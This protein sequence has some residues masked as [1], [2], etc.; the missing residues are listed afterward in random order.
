MD[1]RQLHKFYTCKMAT[2]MSIPPRLRWSNFVHDLVIVDIHQTDINTGVRVATLLIIVTVLGLITKVYV[3]AFE[4]LFRTV[5]SAKTMK[6][7]KS[8]F[9]MLSGLLS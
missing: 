7:T 6:L 3:N 5:I 1:S 8:T 4:S 2:I 9:P